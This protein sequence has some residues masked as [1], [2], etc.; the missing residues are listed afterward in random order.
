MARVEPLGEVELWLPAAPCRPARVVRQ[1]L[2]VQSVTLPARQ[3]TPAVTVTAMLAREEQPP[4]GQP[5]I[6]WR[7]LTNRTVE[8]LEQVGELIDWY[9][10]RW[11]IEIF[12]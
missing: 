1:P 2:Y 5:A 3:G 7:L 8:T 11:L 4:V 10:R 6:E 12:L 9:R